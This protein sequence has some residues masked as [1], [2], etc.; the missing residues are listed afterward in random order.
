MV[1][2]NFN[3]A[4]ISGVFLILL[5]FISLFSVG[6]YAQDTAGTTTTAQEVES[7]VIATAVDTVLIV[8][9]GAHLDFAL[10][11]SIAQTHN[12]PIIYTNLDGATIS[13]EML[14]I[15]ASGAY[16]DAQKVVAIGGGAVISDTLLNSIEGYGEGYAGF[17]TTRIAGTTAVAT[18]VDA[19]EH[20]SV[21]GA[22]A[23]VTFV[24]YHG[25]EFQDDASYTMTLAAQTGGFVIPTLSDSGGLPTIVLEALR[26]MD[27]ETVNYVG[28]FD[29][30][31]AL[32][33]DAGLAGATTGGIIDGENSAIAEQLIDN[34]IAET[35]PGEDVDIVLSEYGGVVPNPSPDDFIIPYRDLDGDNVDDF[36][37][38]VLDGI[39]RGLYDD[40]TEIG[41]RVEH[42]T[43]S[44]D[45]AALLDQFEQDLSDALGDTT[46]VDIGIIDIDE[47]DASVDA[48]LDM[49][50]EDVEDTNHDFEIAEDEYADLYVLHE[51]D[52]QALLPQMMAQFTNY[53]A[54]HRADGT[55]PEDALLLGAQIFNEYNKGD[56]PAVWRLMNEF[57]SEEVY[58]D[59]YVE[60]C[61]GDGRC[62]DEQYDMELMTMEDINDYLG[63]DE[64]VTN[65]E[66]AHEL[67]EL[68]EFVPA[69]EEDV[70]K[71]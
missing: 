11:L 45:D 53:Y 50:R 68:I 59:N 25:D 41:V 44:G 54:D 61:S 58:H 24:S 3:F 4:R 49:H 27:V 14:A 15:L 9:P 48:M 29:N 19:F 64:E 46:A 1:R 8:N 40:F 71:Q 47:G 66:N 51:A 23:E 16:A 57:T 42:I 60:Q 55:L 2:T 18:A 67:M 22:D 13:D 31:D 30:I 20:F 65:I 32:E 38:S 36:S 6:V 5:M 39:G 70:F 62:I 33:E 43:C 21:P 63:L 35:P 34:I 28:N 37:G 69:G 52:F 56:S 17:D 7:A 26:N 10:A 12:Y